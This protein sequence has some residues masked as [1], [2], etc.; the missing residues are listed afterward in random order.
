[1]EKIVREGLDGKSGLEGSEEVGAS[2]SGGWSRLLHKAKNQ[3]EYEE[4]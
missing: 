4:S 3:G 1:M 2:N